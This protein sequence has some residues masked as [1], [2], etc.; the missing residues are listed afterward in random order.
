MAT[1]SD[2]SLSGTWNTLRLTYG[3]GF[4]VL[5]VDKFFNFLVNWQVYLWEEL[6]LTLG[7]DPMLF[8][9]AAG[10]IEVV[11]G[12]AILSRFARAGGYILGTWL[13]LV[14]VNLA[15]AGG[16][17]EV[18]ISQLMLAFGA[19]SFAMLTAPVEY[20]ADRSTRFQPHGI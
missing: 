8:V 14:T 18:A 20:P 16:F 10:V 2:W 7:M 9:Y 13:V 1:F 15:L 5:G 17:W 12:L 4:I 6:P 11:A 3:I 19:Y